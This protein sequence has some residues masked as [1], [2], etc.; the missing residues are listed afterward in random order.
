MVQMQLM[1]DQ[2]LAPLLMNL[3]LGHIRNGQYSLLA[4]DWDEYVIY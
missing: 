3:V 4:E 1:R 2:G